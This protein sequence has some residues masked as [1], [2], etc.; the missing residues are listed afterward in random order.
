MRPMDENAPYQDAYKQVHQSGT[1]SGMSLAELLDN[2]EEEAEEN[3]VEDPEEVK[4]L[5]LAELD[6]LA[7]QVKLVRDALAG[8]AQRS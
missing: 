1:A 3:G 5:L 8:E 6:T 2:V 4:K 7:G